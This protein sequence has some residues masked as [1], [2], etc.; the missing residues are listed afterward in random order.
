MFTPLKK[1]TLIVLLIHN[2]SSGAICLPTGVSQESG[3][4]HRPHSAT[5]M[6]TDTYEEADKERMYVV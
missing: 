1:K 2:A 3:L 4:P 5:S 6:G